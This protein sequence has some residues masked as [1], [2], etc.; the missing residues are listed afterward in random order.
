[1]DSDLR[2]TGASFELDGGQIAARTSKIRD[3]LPE[4]VGMA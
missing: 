3:D 4:P 2:N 1:M